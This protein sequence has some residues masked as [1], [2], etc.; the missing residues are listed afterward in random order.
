M[1]SVNAWAYLSDLRGITVEYHPP[2]ITNKKSP[3]DEGE[4]FLVTSVASPTGFPSTSSGLVN[5]PEAHK[6][7]L[8]RM[9][10]GPFDQ[11]RIKGPGPL[12]LKTKKDTG[13]RQYPFQ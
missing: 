10:C 7:V 3:T 2:I 6:P 4:G 13:R 11:L 8:S 5:A 12:C 9:Q 1:I